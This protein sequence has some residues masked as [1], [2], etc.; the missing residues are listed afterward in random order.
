[1][2]AAHFEDH[3]TDPDKVILRKP[4]HDFNDSEM[5][6]G[7][8]KRQMIIHQLERNVRNETLEE[9]VKE[10]E[11]MTA[12]GPDTIGSFAVYIRNMKR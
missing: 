11:K 8:R 1:M 4:K 12:F 3:P 2:T 7:W 10:I 9:V 5:A 6:M